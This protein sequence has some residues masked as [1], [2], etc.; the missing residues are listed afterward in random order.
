SSFLKY[1]KVLRTGFE[2]AYLKLHRD[3]LFLPYR[4]VS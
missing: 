4:L 3:M 1:F 2:L